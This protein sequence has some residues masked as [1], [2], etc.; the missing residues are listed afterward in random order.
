MSQCS[1]KLLA[2]LSQVA[3]LLLWELG[4]IRINLEEP[5]RLVSGSLSPIYINCRLVISNP[6]FMHFFSSSARILCERNSIHADLVA[7]GETAGIPFAGFFAQSVN[8]PM[9]YVRK[10]AKDH[11]IS[12]RIEGTLRKGAKV[13]LIE[14]LITDAG[15]KMSFIEAIL[16]AGGVVRDVLV[17]FDRQQGGSDALS[18]Q[19][20][21]LHSI[22][23]LDTALRVAKEARLISDSLLT[24]V[25][26]YIR[27][28]IEW[29]ESISRRIGS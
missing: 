9:T 10:A 28:P 6:N 2:D 5:F 16:A 13:L 1:E 26:E 23:N 4:A 15:S 22:T 27:S 8:L 12:S 19:G 11:G 7:G 24:S 29:Q 14:D 17:L 18:G 20:I 25:H 3:A 21:R